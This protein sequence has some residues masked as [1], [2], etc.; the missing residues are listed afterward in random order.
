MFSTMTGIAEPYRNRL[1]PNQEAAMRRQYI[2][3]R[4]RWANKA[5]KDG[6]LRMA[7]KHVNN[8]QRNANLTDNQKRKLRNLNARIARIRQNR[9]INWRSMLSTMTGIAQPR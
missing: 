2:E 3:N 4:F 5:L 1:T 9:A 7:K 8:L 6:K